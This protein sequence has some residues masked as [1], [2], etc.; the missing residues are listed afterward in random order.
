MPVH[1]DPRPPAA[2]RCRSTMPPRGACL[3]HPRRVA[4]AARARASACGV[5]R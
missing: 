5:C 1:V 4:L 2:C 3:A